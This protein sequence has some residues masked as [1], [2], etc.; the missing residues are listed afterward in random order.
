MQFAR[1]R[2]SKRHQWIVRAEAGAD[3]GASLALSSVRP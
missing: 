3:T 2:A 1:N